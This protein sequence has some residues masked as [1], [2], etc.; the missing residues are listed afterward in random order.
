[1]MDLFRG[2]DT[3]ASHCVINIL[4]DD[5]V[6]NINY[7]L[8]IRM[9]VAFDIGRFFADSVVR[10]LNQSTTHSFVRRSVCAY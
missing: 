6:Y 1:M 5:A 2:Y 8:Y 10:S 3:I 7:I 9:F 4:D